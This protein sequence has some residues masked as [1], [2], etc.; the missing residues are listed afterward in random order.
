VR[1]VYQL[2]L[3]E[4]FQKRYSSEEMQWPS[5]VAVPANL[6]VVVVLLFAFWFRN[7]LSF[8]NFLFF[9]TLHVFHLCYYLGVFHVNYFISQHPT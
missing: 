4:T 2:H 3:S 8:F 5:W 6:S 7:V 1:V 9:F